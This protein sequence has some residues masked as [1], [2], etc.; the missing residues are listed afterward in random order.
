[1][2]AVLVVGSVARV[3][4]HLV[5]LMTGVA[6]AVIGPK[7]SESALAGG[8]AAIDTGVAGIHEAG[9][10]LRMDDVPLPLRASV[11]GVIFTEGITRALSERIVTV[12]RN[13]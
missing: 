10:A 11:G 6:S 13:R 8:V 9:T 3:P 12:R 7:A 2:D 5:T 4:A 1:V